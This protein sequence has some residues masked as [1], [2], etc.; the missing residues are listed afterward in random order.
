MADI[1][2]PK[3][4]QFN[5]SNLQ[6]SLVGKI[7]PPGEPEIKT[8]TRINVAAKENL[9]NLRKS[10]SS[11][12]ETQANNLDKAAQDLV[13]QKSDEVKKQAEEAKKQAEE[14]KKKAEEAIKKAEDL[15]AALKGFKIPRLPKVPKFKPKDLFVPN[16]EKKKNAELKKLKDYI[17]STKTEF[18][19]TQQSIADYK[20]QAQDTKKSFDEAAKS[21]TEKVNKISQDA[22]NFATQNVNSAVGGLQ[23]LSNQTSNLLNR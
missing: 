9:S 7:P 15:A 18:N 4:P 8:S 6:N 10:L 22:Q 3:A 23:N 5:V 14:A 12:I 1:I 21:A 16:K 20:K 11:N 2:K 17:D 19:K 13:K